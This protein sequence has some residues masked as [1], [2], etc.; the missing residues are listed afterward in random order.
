MPSIFERE[1]GA[2]KSRQPSHVLS[3]KAPS[4]AR[5]S[6]KMSGRDLLCS[7]ALLF[8]EFSYPFG[9]LK[10]NFCYHSR[11]NWNPEPIFLNLVI[12]TENLAIKGLCFKIFML[13]PYEILAELFK[14]RLKLPFVCAVEPNS[15]HEVFKVFLF[16]E[17]AKD[18][19]DLP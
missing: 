19:F 6:A 17:A 12:L 15:H 5:I 3:S 2:R 13:G 4:S 14:S 16:F 10:K 7:I 9:L 11:K 1:G 8:Q 18:G